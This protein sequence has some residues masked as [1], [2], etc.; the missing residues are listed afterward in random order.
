MKKVAKLSLILFLLLLPSSQLWAQEASVG[1]VAP[2]FTFDDAC[3]KAKALAAEPFKK[4]ENKVPNFLLS[5]QLSYDQWRDIRFKPEKSLWREDNLP[6]EVQFFHVGL[7]YNIS[8]AVSVIDGA[9]VKPINFDSN[10]FDYG[11]NKDL[12]AKLPKDLGVA[13]FRL[14]FP[15]K[16]NEYKDEV[17]VFLGASYFRGIGKSHYYGLSARGLA[18]DTAAAKRN[19]EFPFFREFWLVKPKPGDTSITIYALLDSPSSAGA[20]E[21]QI[22]P[23]EETI[24]EVRSQLI[25][26]HK[27]TTLGIAP[28][29]SMFFYGESDNCH[30]FDDFRPEIHDS[31][32]LA[33]LSG[34]G[35]WLWRPLLSPQDGV[36]TNAFFVEELKGFGLMQRDQA[37]DH[38]Q[39]LEAHYQSRPSAFITPNG[40]WGPGEL[41]LVQIPT[42]S[43]IND[44]IVAFWVPKNPAAP[45]TPM[46][47]NYRLSWQKADRDN[48]YSQTGQVIAT[49]KARGNDEKQVKFVVDF[50]GPELEK[51]PA[52]SPVKGEVTLGP[53]GELLETQ[54]IKNDVTG[55]WRL[56][57][58]VKAKERPVLEEIMGNAKKPLTELRAFL[59]LDGGQVLSETWSYGVELP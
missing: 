12:V 22:I 16:S 57:F 52:S 44:N 9:E 39:D 27:V 35:E 10:F 34:T 26:R 38:Y 36:L 48:P 41:R 49:R 37:Y 47:F 17:A 33:L 24:M 55:G 32:G 29:T 20:Y 14:H 59:T 21:F 25:Q 54:V 13:G 50:E 7:Y 23:G 58:Q 28:L 11:R 45:G 19:E 4:N 56:V 30:R 46:N 53:E 15:I 43:E 42:D 3:A 31:D 8:V 51:L 18:I 6:F 2:A 1:S 5:P 40:D